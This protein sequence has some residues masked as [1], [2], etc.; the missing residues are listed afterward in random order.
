MKKH[1]LT[2]LL[3]WLDEHLEEKVTIDDVITRFSVSRNLLRRM[4]KEELGCTL[5]KY[6]M[7][8]RMFRI[9]LALKYTNT[10]CRDLCKKY[11]Y[12]SLQAFCMAVK[13]FTG[14]SPLEFRATGE[15]NFNRFKQA[16]G[17]LS[18]ASSVIS[19][20]YVYLPPLQL[21]GLSTH[22]FLSPEWSVQDHDNQRDYLNEQFTQ[23][24]PRSPEKVFTL[25]RSVKA[26]SPLFQFEYHIGI[27]YSREHENAC[28]QPLPEISGE[29][30]QITFLGMGMSVHEMTLAAYRHIFAEFYLTRREGYDLGIVE[31]SPQNKNPFT[32]MIP[33]HYDAHLVAM[34]ASQRC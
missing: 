30:L 24:A 3:F 5:P 1:L 19:A 34:L 9:L 7:L 6:I 28:F 15:I 23:Y 8:R 14:S 13:R 4:F 17:L 22:Y 10:L 32:L 2:D 25:S 21:T 20:D 16:L 12:P 18:H 33:V 27:P 29:Y 31:S 11:Q 26:H